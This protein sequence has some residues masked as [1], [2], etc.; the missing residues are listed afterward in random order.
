MDSKYIII[1]TQEQF[2]EFSRLAQEDPFLENLRPMFEKDTVTFPNGVSYVLEQDR[3]EYC[4]LLHK[5][6]RLRAKAGL[7]RRLRL[8]GEAQD[9]AFTAFYEGLKKDLSRTY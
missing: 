6:S 8:L 3:L 5:L 7:V 1:F 9:R 4:L 2:N